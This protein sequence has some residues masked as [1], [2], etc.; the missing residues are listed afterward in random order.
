MPKTADKYFHTDPW[1]VVEKGYDPSHGRV[2][3]SVFALANEHMGVRGSFDEGGTVDSLPGCYINGL[4]EWD[5][6]I[7]SFYKGEIKRTHFMASAVNWISTA[8]RL[9]G[10]TLD[11]A[12]SRF[13]DFTRTLD[14]SKGT[15]TRKFIWRTRS[16]KALKLSFLRFLDMEEETRAYQQIRLT[17]L[18]FDGV[19]ELE[20]GLDFDV[21]HEIKKRRCWNELRFEH[22]A[23]GAA[24]FGETKES[25]HTVFAGFRLDLP[26]ETAPLRREK[27]VGLSAVLNLKQGQTACVRKTAVILPG[28]WEE[29]QDELDRLFIPGAETLFDKAA[30][31][32]K[33]YWRK[34]W[35]TADILIE[36]D[37]ENQQ[38]IRFCVF[39]LM[40]TFRGG[41]AGRNIGAKGLTGEEYHG[42]A[43]W[44][45]EVCCLPFY[46]F[47]EPAAARKLL[48]FRQTTLPQAKRRAQDLGC[49]GAC[50]PVCTINGEEAGFLWQYSMLQPQPTTSV[51]Y[52]LYH[53]AL[54]TG[55]TDYLY[56]EG[57][58]MLAE[59]ARYLAA[60]A[61]KSQRTGKYGFYGV[62]G[63]DEFHLMVDNNCY[64]NYM[65]CRT[66][67]V[68]ADTVENMPAPK[69]AA[70]EEI[71]LWREI[72]E[73][74]FIPKE[75][76]VYEQHDGF[77]YLPHTDIGKIPIEQF[78]LYHHWS[79]DRLFRTDMIKQ[80][81]VLMIMF[82]YNGSF[83]MEEKR[84]NYDY[85]EPRTI[86]ESSLSPAIHSIL[87]AELGR[88]EEAQKFFAF[89]TRIDLDDYNRNTREGLHLT[90]A[91]AAWLNIVYG[92]A[93]LRS[94]TP[95][96]GLSPILPPEWRRLSFRLYIR[97]SLLH[98]DITP[99]ETALRVERGGAV[100]LKVYGKDCTVG[101]G[102]V[103]I[104][105]A[106]RC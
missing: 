47:S 100:T 32:N 94:D 86:H 74:M 28:S 59:I 95:E 13:E 22:R 18:N 64:T 16:G 51:A 8:L 50:Y 19:L 43:F 93:G 75:G 68:A 77:F 5:G 3:E 35:E 69:A 102:E 6:Q 44:D 37:E 27:F 55:D 63:P 56:E 17:P 70:E 90:A 62:M 104:N 33:R 39:Q 34:R 105:T 65:G 30:A 89:A 20:S 46:L 2:A 7:N 9:D 83:T 49:E 101:A 92:F 78:P 12:V 53:Y 97:N 52:G 42:L 81:D 84:A 91:A 24:I 66:L 1:K 38:G 41:K 10:E 79:Y 61:G 72:A 31:S 85:Y 80:A 36:G 23:N 99:S 29:G 54:V 96:L 71:S 98:I 15:L 73:N 103:K 67:L 25:K 21:L 40:Q 82:L 57:A 48:E 4:W 88:L 76:E 60:R 45:T 11:L 14:M 26:A 106:G 58:G 87:A